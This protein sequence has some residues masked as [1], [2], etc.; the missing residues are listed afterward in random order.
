MQVLETFSLTNNH[1]PSFC[2]WAES[3]FWGGYIFF[4]SLSLLSFPLSHS[5]NYLS[6]FNLSNFLVEKGETW[7]SSDIDFDFFEST[8]SLRLTS[9]NFS[10]PV[11]EQVATSTLTFLSS[12][13]GEI[14]TH[15][16]SPNLSLTLTSHII[17][18]PHSL[19][20]SFLFW[21]LVLMSFT[22]IST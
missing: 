13:W 7:S 9:Y 2:C 1:S 4:F 3:S 15:L 20:V 17:P 21:Y 10:S 22:F 6:H 12:T 16:F 18:S 19:L 11:V 14:E 8:T 5:L